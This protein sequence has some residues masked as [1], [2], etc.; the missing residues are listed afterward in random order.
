MSID[1]VKKLKPVLFKYNDTIPE[2]KDGKIHMGFMAQDLQDIFGKDYAIVSDNKNTGYLM[3]QYH[4][5]IA[6]LTKAI[7]ELSDKVEKL[8]KII[9]E[10][11]K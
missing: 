1:L 10:N 8:E 3:V 11:K 6:P 4:E 5:L 9:E 2:L 7:Q